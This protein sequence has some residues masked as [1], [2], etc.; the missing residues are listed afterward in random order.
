[1][2]E[3][4]N[5]EEVAEELQKLEVKLVERDREITNLKTTLDEL[6]VEIYMS[7]HVSELKFLSRSMK[8]SWYRGQKIRD[9]LIK[10]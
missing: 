1:M 10:K 7:R 9:E 3:V 5:L 4:L 2:E 6:D 8:E